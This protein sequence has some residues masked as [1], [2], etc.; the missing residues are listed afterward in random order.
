MLLATTIHAYAWLCVQ[1]GFL[2]SVSGSVAS[3]AHM[4]SKDIEKMEEDD[5]EESDDEYQVSVQDA[6]LWSSYPTCLQDLNEIPAWWK[7]PSRGAFSEP[8][9]PQLQGLTHIPP[10]LAHCLTS[11]WSAGDIAITEK[12][13]K[14]VMIALKQLSMMKHAGSSYF[15]PDPV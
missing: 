1:T 15:P 8:P 6:P 7:D 14:H 2:A 13:T 4:E 10:P 3:L 5:S 12:A 11:L 9:P